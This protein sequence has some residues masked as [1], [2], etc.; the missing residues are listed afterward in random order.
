LIVLGAA[1]LNFQG[2][3]TLTESQSRYFG[4]DTP[5]KAANGQ[6]MDRHILVGHV[7]YYNQ[8]RGAGYICAT[9]PIV[10]S[11]QELRFYFPATHFLSGSAVPPYPD[12]SIGTVVEFE[13][14][15]PFR[16]GQLPEGAINVRKLKDPPP[17]PLPLTWFEKLLRRLHLIPVRA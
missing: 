13:L 4:Q 14:A 3:I 1:R 6:M 16:W 7:V 10:H 17:P 15:R 5:Q 9:P 12:I 11:G 8:Q 2:G